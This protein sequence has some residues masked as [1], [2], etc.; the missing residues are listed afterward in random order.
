MSQVT[1]YLFSDCAYK[2]PFLDAL[3][4]P[5]DSDMWFTPN[6]LLFKDCSI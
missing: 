4:T 3:N 1:H 5:R 6:N 2:R